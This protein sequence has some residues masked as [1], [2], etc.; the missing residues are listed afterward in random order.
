MLSS[1]SGNVTF[2]KFIHLENA[3]LQTLVT[4]SS[5]TTD[6]ILSLYSSHGCDVI[7]PVPYTYNVPFAYSA[8]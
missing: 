2:S 1:V 3:A 8:Q 5:I 6:K 7:S 4:P